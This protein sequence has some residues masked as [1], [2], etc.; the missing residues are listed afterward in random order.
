MRQL[1]KIQAVR[2]DQP[3]FTPV[4]WA[5]PSNT[6]RLNKPVC[7]ERLMPILQGYIPPTGRK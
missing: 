3:M 5:S 4:A 7:S 2:V 1:Q 6:K